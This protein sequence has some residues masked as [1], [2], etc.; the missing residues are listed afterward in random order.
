ML[1]SGQ[2]MFNS[3]MQ[4]V[5]LSSD[6]YNFLPQTLFILLFMAANKAVNK[7]RI[8][9]GNYSLGGF[10]SCHYIVF[11][12]IITLIFFSI[13]ESGFL[14]FLQI[15]RTKNSPVVTSHII[16]F[17]QALSGTYSSSSGRTSVPFLW[18]A[19]L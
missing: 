1:H 2:K 5:I 17:L 4:C 8:N 12:I 11:C 16:I 9:T 18:E 7:N 19:L 14:L 10:C 13:S 3:I 15:I 6:A